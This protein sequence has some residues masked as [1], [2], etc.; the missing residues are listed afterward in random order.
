MYINLSRLSLSSDSVKKTDPKDT[1]SYAES[2]KV[3]FDALEQG[4]QHKPRRDVGMSLI[5]TYRHANDVIGCMEECI[6][7][8]LVQS[9]MELYTYVFWQNIAIIQ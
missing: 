9:W 5:H 6:Y 7:L 4:F 8:M 2:R 1:I 3:E